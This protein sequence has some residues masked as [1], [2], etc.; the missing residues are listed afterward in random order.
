MADG[1]I[2]IDVI[3]NDQASESAKKIDDLLKNVGA[4]AGDKAEEN[5]K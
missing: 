3:V 4:D 5:I 1:K 2:D